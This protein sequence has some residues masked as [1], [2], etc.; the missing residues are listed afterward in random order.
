MFW[1]GNLYQPYMYAS[2]VIVALNERVLS[3]AVWA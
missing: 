2:N 1:H 3:I